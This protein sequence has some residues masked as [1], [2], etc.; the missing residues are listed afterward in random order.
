MTVDAAPVPDERDCDQNKHYDQNDTL[1]VFREF[2][3]SEQLFHF[4]VAQ[5]RYLRPIISSSSGVL[6]VVILSEAK[7]L[8]SFFG[9]AHQTNSWRCFALLNMIRTLASFFGVTNRIF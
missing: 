4:I 3:D 6:Q 1:F 7:N 8:R 9:V 2:E 5:L